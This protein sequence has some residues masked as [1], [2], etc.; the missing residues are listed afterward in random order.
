MPVKKLPKK[1]VTRLKKAAPA[2]E[3]FLGSMKNIDHRKDF[4]EARG[5][6]KN[7]THAW[8]RRVRELNISRNFP[9]TKSVVIKMAHSVGAEGTI[10]TLSEKVRE[11]NKRFGKENYV[12]LEPKAYAINRDVLAMAKANNPNI[13]EII[14]SGRWQ[15]DKTRRGKIFFKKLKNKYNVSEEQLETAAEQVFERTGIQRANL[16]LLGFKKGKFIFMP[17][18]DIC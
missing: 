5:I 12:L 3:R 15:E 6:Q 7:S 11:H 9:R 17:L 1:L 10:K 14:G 18:V 4:P 13:H 16:L 2:V 8:G